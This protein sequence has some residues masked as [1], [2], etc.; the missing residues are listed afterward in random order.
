MLPIIFG[1]QGHSMTE[2]EREFFRAVN[3]YGFILFLRNIQ[4]PEQ[5]NALIADLRATVGRDDAPIL[6]DQEG[7]RVQRLRP[8]HWVDLPNARALGE[9]YDVDPALG[10]RATTLQA[11]AIAGMLGELGID[12]VCAPVMDLPVEGAHDVIGNRAFS[13]DRDTVVTMTAHMADA[14]RHNGV[15]AIMKHIPGHG[16]AMADSHDE[17]PVVDLDLA[18]LEQTDFAVFKDAAKKMGAETAWAMTAHVVFPALDEAPVSVSK[19]A[20]DYL[21]NE[22]G[23]NGPIIPD[24]IEMEALGGTLADRAMATLNAGCDAV[25]HC[26]GKLEDMKAIA[27]VLPPMT[28]TALAR[29]QKAQAARATHTCPDWRKAHQELE[30]LLTIQSADAYKAHEALTIA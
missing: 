25:L 8:P 3:P 13:F 1:L 20:M 10:L 5:V 29:F 28:A 15:T 11:Q 16:R 30:T 7:G 17:C 27:A 21:R 6:I 26:S 23:I 12:V 22:L 2:D 4:S 9:L 19:K 18:T 14:L 24:A